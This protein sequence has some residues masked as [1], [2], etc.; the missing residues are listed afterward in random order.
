MWSGE[1]WDWAVWTATSRSIWGSHGRNSILGEEA[2]CRI[3][4]YKG[5]NRIE[6]DPKE[7][8]SNN[9]KETPNKRP[10]GQEKKTSKLLCGKDDLHFG[11]SPEEYSSGRDL[12]KVVSS[13]SKMTGAG[14]SWI[15]EWL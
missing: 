13:M 15:G 10:E 4:L 5:N 14:G 12:Y 3:P 6:G 11:T 7:K 1:L 9:P 2:A 8:V